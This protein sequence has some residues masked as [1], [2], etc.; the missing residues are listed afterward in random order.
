MITREPDYRLVLDGRDLTPRLK[1][2][3]PGSTRARLVSLTL[4]EKRGE[5]ADQ[6]DLVLDDGDGRLA[7]PP[8]GATLQLSIGWLRG[9]DVALG[10]VDK[11][12]FV[13]D[14]VAHAGPPDLLTI[15]ARSADFTGTLKT[16]RERSWRGTTLGAIVAD[17]ARAH[18]L[19]PRCAASLAAITI[20]D[21]AQSRE[22]DLAFLRR[23]GR[24]C[25]AV[26]TV[27][28]G[29]LILAPIGAG[30]T[31]TGRSL[32]SI[33]IHRRDGDTHDFARR[34]RDEVDGVTATWH[35]RASGSRRHVT[36]GK[37]DGARRLAKV[38]ATEA[39]AKAAAATAHARATRQPVTL[40]LTLAAGQA[41]LGPEQKVTVVGY[42]PAIDAVEWLIAEVAHEIGDRGFQTR[43]RLEAA[44]SRRVVTLSHSATP[45]AA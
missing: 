15:R 12:T 3:V 24:E 34:K 17:V 39:D 20:T 27:K 11:G 6:L 45:A 1:G 40:G 31:P 35:D 44:D 19:V 8:E 41:D 21:K 16:R 42:K 36:S 18:G 10:L 30:V 7:I 14:E 25:D 43:V 22:S 13:V 2:K 9:S 5:E 38:H 32:P 26:A 28:R 23:L 37:A 29:A 33:T 4:T